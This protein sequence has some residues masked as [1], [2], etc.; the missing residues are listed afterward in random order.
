MVAHHFDTNASR[1]QQHLQK[2]FQSIYESL[3]DAGHEPTT[4][5]RDI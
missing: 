1:S 5:R 2:A 4:V 3:C